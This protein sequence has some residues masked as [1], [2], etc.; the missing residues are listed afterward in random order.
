MPADPADRARPGHAQSSAPVTGRVS[1]TPAGPAARRS[2]ATM[3]AVSAGSLAVTG[4]RSCTS[5]TAVAPALAAMAAVATALYAIYFLILGV[6]FVWGRVSAPLLQ[7]KALRGVMVMALLSPNA[8]NTFVY[9]SKISI[10]GFPS[11]P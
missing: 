3:R 2:V 5:T 8:F 1:L 6:L 11:N 9:F 7:E 4:V 10:T